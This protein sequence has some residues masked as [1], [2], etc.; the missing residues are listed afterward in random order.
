MDTGKNFPV[1]VAAVSIVGVRDS[2]VVADVTDVVIDPDTVVLDI[3]G[4][5]LAWVLD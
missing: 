4:E 2:A 1:L 3:Y 5:T